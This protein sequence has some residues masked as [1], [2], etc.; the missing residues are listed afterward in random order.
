VEALAP[1]NVGDV[2]TPIIH[3][4]DRGFQKFIQHLAKSGSDKR[5]FIQKNYVQMMDSIMDENNEDQ[6]DYEEKGDNDTSNQSI[7]IICK[8]KE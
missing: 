2:E 1:E 5:F 4:A 8:T 6:Q 3:N 7:Y